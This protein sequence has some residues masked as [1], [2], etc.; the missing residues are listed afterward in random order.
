MSAFAIR[1]MALA[2]SGLLVERIGGPSVRP[3]QPTGIW[4]DASLGKIGYT[5]DKG[6]GLYRRS[7]YTFWRRIA[8]PTMFFDASSRNVCTVKLPR[9]N[10]PLQAL[11]L[12]NDITYVEAARKLAERVLLDGG[13]T[14]DARITFAFRTAT[15]RHPTPEEAALLS[16][17]LTAMKSSFA[18]NPEAASKLISIGD[19]PRHPS[20]DPIDLAA[21]TALMNLILNLDEAMTKE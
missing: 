2:M 15:S 1:D 7:L 8:A 16:E 3:Y 5:P 17:S 12:M 4:E 18:R 6:E 14:T 10:T 19:S 9:T 11:A 13:E 21:H 20:L